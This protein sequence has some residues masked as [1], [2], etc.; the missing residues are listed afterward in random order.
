MN[1]PVLPDYE[2]CVANL[3]NSILKYFG[4]EPAGSS[5]KLLDK[6]LKEDY[7]NVVLLVLDGLGCS[8]LGWNADRMGFMRTHSVGNVNSV[9]PSA[10]VA[11]TT[12]LM[13][14]LQ[15]CEH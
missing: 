5:S 14:G 4:A 12:S 2:N 9:F 11:A 15:P 7:K 3:P 6:Y 8:I 13:T 1:H 10:T